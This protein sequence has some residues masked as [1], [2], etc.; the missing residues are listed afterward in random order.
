[1]L[2]ETSR[3]KLFQSFIVWPAEAIFVTS[4]MLSASSDSESFLKLLS[5]QATFH[6]SHLLLVGLSTHPSP[7]APL[8]WSGG[9]CV[10]AFENVEQ[11]LFCTQSD[12][13]DGTQLVGKQLPSNTERLREGTV[14]E[15]MEEVS[16]AHEIRDV[17]CRSWGKHSKRGNEKA[18]KLKGTEHKRSRALYQRTVSSCGGN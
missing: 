4:E 2:P 8:L 1:M 5:A 16:Q 12:F 17:K 18:E 10:A 6:L 15:F 9:C 3:I 14:L 13:P 11:K 7:Q